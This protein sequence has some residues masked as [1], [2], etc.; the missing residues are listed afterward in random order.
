MENLSALR[1]IT[2]LLG[3]YDV[4]TD[5]EQVIQGRVEK[6]GVG[7]NSTDANFC[8]SIAEQILEGRYPSHKQLAA[9]QKILPKYQ[10]QIL[11][12]DHDYQATR[13]KTEV[14]GWLE[15]YEKRSAERTE[16]AEVAS[17]QKKSSGV[18]QFDQDK[19]LEFVPKIYP[20]NVCKEWGFKRGQRESWTWVN[21][22]SLD[23][24]YK[25]Q[26]TFRDLEIQKMPEELENDEVL[27]QFQK[28]AIQFLRTRDKA[29]LALA[30]GL[31]KTVCSIKA[32][33]NLPEAKGMAVLVVAPLSLLYN[34]RKEIQM[35]SK[36]TAAVWHGSPTKWEDP[37]SNWV[38][39]NYDTL[40]RQVG[41]FKAIDWDILIID[42]SVMIKN[43]KAKRTETL[44]E[45]SSKIPIVWELSGAPTTR[46]FDDM[47]AELHLLSPRR[48]R[49][50]WRFAKEYCNVI[51]NGWANE[52]AANLP[53]AADRIKRDLAD[54]YYCRTQDQVLNLPEFIFENI[55]IPM[56]ESDY[57]IYRS[58][59]QDLL[60]NLPEGDTVAAGNILTQILR[61]VQMASNPGIL[62]KAEH[63]SSKWK[64]AVEMLEY[65]ELPA[66]IW[67]NFVATA[68]RLASLVDEAGHS[69]AIL[70]GDTNQ[71]VRQSIV[72]EFQ[73]G[74][75][76]VIIAHPGV[77]KFGLTL[78]KARTAIYL[79]RSYNGDDYFQ[80]LHRVRRIG[81]KDS[82]HIIHLLST[83]P[84]EGDTIDHV[85]NQVLQYRKHQNVQLTT[86]LLKTIGG[87]NGR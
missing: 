37:E 59:E 39:T 75:I 45:F 70:T 17:V 4:Q 69:V 27:F 84:K 52:I 68:K 61:L 62:N 86:G 20:T 56:G 12:I 7:F 32:A 78:T 76:D 42:E 83:S 19:R 3:L 50:Y 35:W 10:K 2:S 51:F 14:L 34:W 47:W 63:V 6:N 29:L 24:Y 8:T 5:E 55:E 81:T 79:E 46:F 26:A 85:I 11:H 64:A 18:V 54:I 31:G 40:V 33:E 82:P 73:N 23:S 74:Q 77:G 16:K 15:S 38:V 13:V 1:S 60:A 28:E 21:T 9:L 48:F 71:E 43:R 30:P 22:F 72:E 58:M 41:S 87:Q 36:K 66:I 65:E 44:T 53:D 80:S 25:L 67:V 57:K 49:S